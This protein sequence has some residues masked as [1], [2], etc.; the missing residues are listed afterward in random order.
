MLHVRVNYIFFLIWYLLTKQQQF[1]CWWIPKTISIYFVEPMSSLITTYAG[2]FFLCAKIYHY[3]HILCLSRQQKYYPY[4]KYSTDDWF[5]PNEIKIYTVWVFLGTLTD[6]LW[7]SSRPIHLVVVH[8]KTQ[9]RLQYQ[10]QD[11]DPTINPAFHVKNGFLHFFCHE[12]T[13]IH[14]YK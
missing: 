6:K 11:C 12:S 3:Q 10:D 8:W 7:L 9:S 4:Q 5:I 13:Q 1:T 2:Y 14:K